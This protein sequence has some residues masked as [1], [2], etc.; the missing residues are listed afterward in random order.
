MSARLESLFSNL[1]QT[2]YKIT[3]EESR[4]YNCIAFAAGE[5]HRWWWPIGA[6]WPEQAPRHET[7]ESFILAFHALGY[8]P[9]DDGALEVGYEK[10]VIYADESGVPT[11]MARQLPS[12]MWTSKCGSLEDIEHETLE[13]LAG[14]GPS[15]YGAVVRFFKRAIQK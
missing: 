8:A 3:S 5:T 6:Y 4:W 12:G 15:E 9:C 2:Q 11:H 13:A 14:F 7:I 10:V 1:K